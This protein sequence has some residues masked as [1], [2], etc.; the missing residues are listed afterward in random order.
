MSNLNTAPSTPLNHPPT[1]TAPPSAAAS[2]VPAAAVAAPIASAVP[3]DAEQIK[4]DMKLCSDCVWDVQ[5]LRD[6][7]YKI[8]EVLFDP[9]RPDAIIAVFPTGSGKSHAIRVIG[10]M[11]RGIH[12]IFI[13]LLTLSADVMA[14]FCSASQNHG[15]VRA[16]HLDELYDNN[17]TRYQELI[18]RCADLKRSTDSTVFLF[19]SPQHLCK[20]VSAR[21]TLIRCSWYGTLRT[22]FMDEVHLHVQHGLSFRKECRMLRDYF[23]VKCMHPPDRQHFIPYF[24]GLSATFP[25]DYTA[26][27]HLLTS[28]PFGDDSVIRGDIEDFFNTDILMKQVICNKGEY[29][30]IGLEEL[31][32][33]IDADS[34]N[35]CLIFCNS[36]SKAHHYCS[37]LESKLN[38]GNVVCDVIVITGALNKHEKFWRIRILLGSN[39]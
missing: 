32:K 12:L 18:Q 3:F 14:K 4:H 11:Q 33:N 29:V 13:P 20:V 9:N 5:E 38:N 7:Q 16:Y 10:A 36:R 15:S 27:L 8:G 2:A 24:V 30:K 26:G 28:I 35:K 1:T 39:S 22:I 31:I 21:T 25:N 34:D 19:L 23:F 6:H 37:E 17:R